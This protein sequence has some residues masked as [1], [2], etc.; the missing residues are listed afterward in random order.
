MKNP[1][2][3]RPLR[4]ATE[5]AVIVI[6]VVVALG[7]DEW[8]QSM[9]DA[10]EEDRYYRRLA[11]DLAG[12]IDSW[13]SL[14]ERLE[15]KDQALARLEAWRSNP[16]T[17]NTQE[18]RTVVEDIATA[19]VY[20]GSI[21]PPR[22][23]TYEDLLS[24]GNLDL[25]RDEEFRTG[26]LNYHFEIRNGISRINART[27]GYD[28]LAFRLVPREL[29]DSSDNVAQRNLGRSELLAIADRALREDLQSF[30]IA[31]RN[32]SNF[33]RGQV[34]SFLERASEIRDRAADLIDIGAIE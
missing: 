24:T 14:L 9:A 34:G 22:T 25:I 20:A 29:K 13:K 8:R 5:F 27:T 16:A 32:R 3:S 2:L 17:S 28:A 18:A 31:E 4:L 15:A 10:A 11:L 21:P 12:D 7:F 23:A 26:L 30:L 33:L 6:G 1:S 19:A